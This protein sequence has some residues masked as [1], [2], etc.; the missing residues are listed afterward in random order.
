VNGLGYIFV[1]YAK[2]DIAASEPERLARLACLEQTLGGSSRV[3]IDE[4]HN[5][6]GG[7]PAVAEALDNAAAVCVVD[8]HH[9]RKRPWPRWEIARAKDLGIPVFRTA[10][11][12]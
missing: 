1:S 11:I 6:D 8:G 5:A 2:L 4:L 10:S 9:H 3:F 12:G 7:H